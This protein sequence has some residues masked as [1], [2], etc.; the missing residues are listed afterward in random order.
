[1]KFVSTAGSSGRSSASGSSLV[2]V[3][4]SVASGSPADKAGIRA[5]QTQTAAGLVA[6]GDLIVGVDGKPISDP[7][8]ISNAIATKKPGDKV[9]I[10]FYRGRTKK[11]VTLTLAD[12]PA[13]APNTP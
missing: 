7:T 12:R 2:S 5:G 8:D 13:K 3:V 11:S 1:M 10:E 9:T 4:V 6:G